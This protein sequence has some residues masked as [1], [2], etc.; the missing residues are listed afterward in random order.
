MTFTAALDAVLRGR[1][2]K[3]KLGICGTF[4]VRNFGDL[5]FPLIAQN[6]LA[7]RLG[8][9]ELQRYAYHARSTPAWTFDVTPLSRLE[10]DMDTIDGMIVG[11]GHLI[12]F[13]KD[14]AP[15]YLPP[16]PEI[17]H[18]TGYWLTPAVLA[19]QRGRPLAWNAPGVY[20]EV[21]AW[22]EGL[23]KLAFENSRYI[24]VRDEPSRAALTR[25]AG[26]TEI[27]VVP[28]TAF[29][30]AAL[31]NSGGPLP[32]VE[33]RHATPKPRQPYI[34][35]QPGDGCIAAAR[36][37]S[38]ARRKLKEFQIVSLPIGPDL[39]DDDFVLRDILPDALRFPDWPHPLTIIEL[40]RD[41]SG[42]ICESLHATITAL[43]LGVPVFRS[44]GHSFAGKYAPLRKF[45][46]V[47]EIDFNAGAEVQRL[48]DRLGRT[49]PEAAV[50]SAAAELDL[51]W[52]KM[53]QALS[54]RNNPRPV[55]VARF[56]QSLPIALEA[57]HVQSALLQAAAAQERASAQAAPHPAI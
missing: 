26:G 39:G 15:N 6:E 49:Q 41:S 55:A 32:D 8:P 17:P 51:H 3:M 38:A 13:D 21:P 9:V 34:I 7:K 46:S 30:V 28:D 35:I 27:A 43:A 50:K 37:L 11:G 45:D 2:A 40:I 48:F 33:R 44:D 24:A 18:P 42:I 29:G 14:V 57:S 19:V 4:D 31:V 25:F 36:A 52:N 56:L 54:E 5:L 20:G 16:D 10:R 22:A 47:F 12:R 53:A 23:M 1:R